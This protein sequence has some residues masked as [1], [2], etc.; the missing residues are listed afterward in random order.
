MRPP[1]EVSEVRTQERS[2][3]ADG[4]VAK[5]NWIEFIVYKQLYIGGK[6]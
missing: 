1:R 4:I 2:P 5:K 6:G 3:V